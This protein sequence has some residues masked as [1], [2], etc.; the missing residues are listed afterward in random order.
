MAGTLGGGWYGSRISDLFVLMRQNNLDFQGSSTF[1][2]KNPQIFNTKSLS[3]NSFGAR[4][5]LGAGYA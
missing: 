4:A 1:Y 2:A 3:S 5:K